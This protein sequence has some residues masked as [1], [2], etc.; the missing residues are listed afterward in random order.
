MKFQGIFVDSSTPFDSDG[1]LYRIKIEHNIAKWNQTSVAGYI[2]GGYCGEGAFLSAEEKLELWKLSAAAAGPAK[3]LIA[4]V[5]EAGTIEAARMVNLAA[6]LGFHAALVETPHADIRMSRAET[7]LLFYRSVADRARIPVWIANRPGATG[8]ALS[9]DTLAALAKHPNIG[10]I[11]DHSGEPSN[12]QRLG[13]AT[14]LWGDEGSLWR[15]LQ[16]GASGAA[17]AL[18]NAVP[19]AAIALWEAHRTREDD[20]GL[21]WQ[22]RI[23]P[24]AELVC[25]RLPIAGLKHAM[26]VN[27]Y[28]GGQPRL[29]LSGL[30]PA[31]KR[32]VEQAFAY[33]KS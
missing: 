8:V 32:E 16:C 7:Q 31:Q 3:I 2:L 6:D 19:F 14:L 12:I 15:A 21:D 17:L 23:A 29:P 20:A 4:G 10:G 25:A 13:G 26:D 18:A 22:S 27:G 30:N 1:A 33:L 24:P 11:V 5:D 9:V 28:Y